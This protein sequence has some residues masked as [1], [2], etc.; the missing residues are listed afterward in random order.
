MS[1]FIARHGGGAGR[2]PW[3]VYLCIPMNVD[4][5]SNGRC[6]VD[7]EFVHIERGRRRRR[8]GMGGTARRRSGGRLAAPRE[9]CWRELERAGRGR[10]G[11]RPG[12][13]SGERAFG[14]GPHFGQ[15]IKHK[16]SFFE[17][18]SAKWTSWGLGNRFCSPSRSKDNSK[19][20]D[21]RREG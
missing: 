18:S 14:T 3:G 4:L 15:Y 5:T 13:G 20:G 17:Y 8:P 19:K 1:V 21:Y 10:R 16:T 11:S 2:R 6:A 12:P 7:R 9:S